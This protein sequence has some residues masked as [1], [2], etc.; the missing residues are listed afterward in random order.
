MAIRSVLWGVALV[1]LVCI[2][3]VAEGSH[4]NLGT[5]SR[6]AKF[7]RNEARVARIN[8]CDTCLQLSQEAQMVLANPDTPKEVINVADQLVCSPLQPG[9]KKKCERMVD[10]YV[11][12]AI[13][14]LEALLGPDKLCF[15]SGLCT[16]PALSAFEDERKSCMVCQDLATD[17]LTYLEN[18]KTR[19]EIVIALH[20]ACAQLKEL[21]KQCDLL[22]D[23]YT[24]RMMEQ[25]E[26]ITPQEFCQM[27]KMC[28]P[29]KR[30]LASND[31]ATC[32]F[33]ILE[34]K[35]KLQDPQTQ[36]KVLDVL[37]NGCNRVVNHVDECKA[38]VVQ[39][40]PFV[41]ANLDKILDSQAVCCKAGFCKSSICPQKAKLWT[42]MMTELLQKD[43]SL[44]ELPQEGLVSAV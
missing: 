19:V 6:L 44:I 43:S 41:L 9:L 11:P 17:A 18:N 34:L 3:S 23:M 35:I 30:V 21:S 20:L 32:Q 2:G 10:Q 40:G 8:L 27:T 4:V 5:V 24:P 15:E 39:Y 1:A 14:E 42:E 31:C 26:N 16:A 37:M 25:L 22:V 38:L 12:Q 33:V 7:T 28:K 36:E 13:L 29:P